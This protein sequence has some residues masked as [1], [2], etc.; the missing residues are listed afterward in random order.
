MP[1]REKITVIAAACNEAEQ[2]AAW[3]EHL[4]WADR[5]VVADSGSVDGTPEILRRGGA[6]VIPLAASPRP[7]IHA[8]KNRALQE[9][10]NGWILDLDLDERVTLALRDELL[11]HAAAA[12]APVPNAAVAYR[13]PFHH[14]VFG[15]WLR[16]GGWRD[17][18]L[19]VYRAGLLAYPEDRAHSTPIVQGEIGDLAGAIV[20]FAHPCL[21]D[22]LVK[23][24]RYTTADAPLIRAHGKGGLRNRAPL[25]ARRLRWLAAS[26]S[27][28]WNRYVKARGFLDGMPGFLAA[29]L[30]STYVFVEQAKVWELEHGRER[31]SAAGDRA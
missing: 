21:H 11:Q 26:G 5:V 20:H 28:L 31:E 9:V 25:P 23:M 18:H 7:L 24:N 10:D 8:A 19:R 22:F 6:E 27:M 14:Y 17:R 16:H 4:E 2:A 12:S 3:L 13:V 1:A 15:R 30:L 29:A